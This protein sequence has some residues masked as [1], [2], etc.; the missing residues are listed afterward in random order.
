MHEEGLTLDLV[1]A[2]YHLA[3]QLALQIVGKHTCVQL[4]H[5]DIV[6]FPKHVES[7]GGEWVD[8]SEMSESHRSAMRVQVIGGREQMA[9]GAAPA[10]EYCVGGCPAR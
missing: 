7:V 1:D 4:R 10:H 5:Y 8:I 6:I 2:A 3:G 9:I